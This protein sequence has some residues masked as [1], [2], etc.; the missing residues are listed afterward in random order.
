MT[1]RRNV[2]KT[3]ALSLGAVNFFTR[4]GKATP[5]EPKTIPGDPS[6]VYPF[7]VPDLG[8][9]Y[10]ALEPIIDT[11]T[12]HLHHDKH[13]AAYV[14]NLNK[15]LAEAGANYQ[16]LTVE[17]L[18][19][20]LDALPPKIRT[21]IRNNAGGHYNHS[22][23]WQFLK[24]NEDSQPQGDLA[25]AIDTTFGGYQAF[26]TKFS[27]AATK[28]F[29]SGWAWLVLNGKT[30]EIVSTPNQDSPISKGQVPILALDVW[31]HSYYLK[32]R[33]KRPEYIKAFWEAVNWEYAGHRYTEAL[34]A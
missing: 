5:I 30:L 9:G 26:T 14:E 4:T 13:H 16:S 11:E 6:G 32:H 25:K 17:Q 31:E 10:D 21:A 7:K 27:E 20:R 33:N 23:F 28:V 22:L 29:G 8:Y 12:M 18:L 1:T 19:T 34:K 24:K 3:I 15:A 2:I